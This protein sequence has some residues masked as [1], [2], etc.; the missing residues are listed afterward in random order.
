MGEVIDLG[1]KQGIVDKA[2]AWYSYNG[3][4]IGQGKSKVADFLLAN[5]KIADDIEARIRTEL[6]PSVEDKN[7]MQDK[8]TKKEKAVE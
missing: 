8:K 3:D 1:V 2:G 6:L 4:R 7:D 5:P